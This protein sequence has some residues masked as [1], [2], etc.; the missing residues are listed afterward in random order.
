MDNYALPPMD[1]KF[2][3][4]KALLGNMLALKKKVP[5][6]IKTLAE[7]DKAFRD[8]LLR[9]GRF[10]IQAGE[11]YFFIEKKTHYAYS[12]AAAINVLKQLPHPTPEYI[13]IL[14]KCVLLLESTF[15][16]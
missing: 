15:L 3:L 12:I 6:K 11:T 2:A 14:G 16:R 1:K 4:L 13:V 5:P 8:K 7:S 9:I 10:L